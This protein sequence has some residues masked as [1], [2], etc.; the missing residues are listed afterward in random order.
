LARDVKVVG[1]AN[2]WR[3]WIV[4]FTVF[5]V[6]K[7]DPKAALTLHVTALSEDDAY[8]EFRQG[9]QYVVFADVNPASKSE[10]FGVRGLTHGAHGC[11]GTGPVAHSASYLKQ[12]GPGEPPKP[13][14]EF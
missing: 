10:R 8:E 9:E 1:N 11:G 6:W 7:G 4:A 3:G 12:L 13:R 5:R 14:V 2:S